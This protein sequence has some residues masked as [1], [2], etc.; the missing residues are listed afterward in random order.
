MFDTDI[1]DSPTNQKLSEFVD[2]SKTIHT[3]AQIVAEWNMNMFDNI[4]LVG[5]YKNRPGEDFT[6][7]S[8]FVE[9]TEATPNKQYLGFTDSDVITDGGYTDDGI[10]LTFLSKSQKNKILYSLEDCFQRFR[11]RSGINKLVMF[12]G[13]YISGMEFD[14]DTFIRPRYYL[15]D[16]DDKFKYWTSYRRESYNKGTDAVEE[17]SSVSIGFNTI[18]VTGAVAATV[19]GE[20]LVTYAI[21]NLALSNPIS[22]GQTISVSGVSPSQFNLQNVKVVSKTL[23]SVT[24]VSEQDFTAIFA[25]GGIMTSVNGNITYT[26]SD[27]GA[28][29]FAVGDVLSIRDATTASA[30]T[31]VES[32][33]DK[34]VVTASTANSFTIN[35]KSYADKIWA[36]T[37]ADPTYPAKPGRIASRYDFSQERGIAKVSSNASTRYID[38]AAPFVAYNN[39]VPANRI[40]T[41]MQ[42]NVS[43]Q[44]DKSKSYGNIPDPFYGSA[45]KTVPNNWKIQYLDSSDNWVNAITLSDPTKIP[46]DGYVEISYGML[47]TSNTLVEGVPLYDYSDTHLIFAEE[48][49]SAASL[50]VRSINNYAYLV[51]SGTSVGTY[52][53]WSDEI[54]DY[55]TFIPEYG[56]YLSSETPSAKTPYVKDLTSPASYVVSGNTY[57]RDIQYIKGIRI[58]VDTMNVSDTPFNLIELSPRLVADLTDKVTKVSMN[59]SSADLGSLGLPIG[60]LLASTGSITMFDYDMSFNSN[61]KNSILNT[62]VDGEYK[63]S[64]PSNNL[65]FKMYDVVYDDNGVSYHVPIKTMYVDGLPQT[66]HTNRTVDLKLRDLFFLFESSNAPQVLVPNASVSFAVASLLDS[67]GFSNYIFYREPDEVETVIPYFYVSPDQNVAQVLQD[68]AI[69]TQTA[70]FFDEYNNFVVMSRNYMLSKDRASDS[71]SIITIKGSKDSVRDGIVSN[72]Q[73]GSLSSIIDIASE[74]SEVF[75]DGKIQFN[76]RYIQRSYGTLQEASLLNTDR[77]WYYQPVLLWEVSPPEN[78]RPINDT[79]GNQ[80]AYSLA[81]IP[82]KADLSDRV[83]TVNP[84]GTIVDNTIDLGEAVYWLPRYNGFF[85]SAGEVIK[86]DAVRYNVPTMPVNDL[87]ADLLAGTKTVTLAYGSTSKM[88]VGQALTEI[89]NGTP[90]SFRIVGASLASNIATIVTSTPHNLLAGN[91]VSVDLSN[92]V[93][94]GQYRITAVTPTTISYAKTSASIAPADLTGRVVSI[95]DKYSVT[96]RSITNNVATLTFGSSHFLNVGDTVLVES[97]GIE[98]NGSYEITAKTSTT[99][100]YARENA[101]VAETTS[102]DGYVTLGARLKNDNAILAPGVKVSKIVNSTKFEV[103]KPHVSTGRA[104]MTAK[105][106]ENLFWIR[107]AEEYGN[108]FSKMPFGGKMYPNGEVR[109]FVEPFYNSDG[110]VK[111]GAVARHGRGQFSTQ[112]TSHSAGIR[113]EWTDKS[114]KDSDGKEIAGKGACRMK[115]EILFGNDKAPDTTQGTKAGVSSKRAYTSGVIRSIGSSKIITEDTIKDQKQPSTGTVQASALIMSGPV[116]GS[117]EK[118][119]RHIMYSYKKLS[120]SYQHYGTRMRIVGELTSSDGT[121][122]PTG[123]MTFADVKNDTGSDNTKSVAGSSGGIG[124]FVNPET[125]Q[126]YYL[127]AVAITDN[128]LLAYDSLYDENNEDANIYNVF[129]YK[130][131]TEKGK[132][133]DDQ[134]IPVPLWKGKTQITVDDG[135]FTGQ[136]KISG[137]PNS[138]VN[139]LAIEYKTNSKD[140]AD[141]DFYIYINDKLVATVTDPMPLPKTPNVALFIRGSSKCMFE[142]VYAIKSRFGDQGE[143]RGFENPPVSNEV[144]GFDNESLNGSLRKFAVSGLIK[145]TVLRGINGSSVPNYD[146]YY[147]EFGSIMRECASFNIKYDKAY[148]ALYAKMSP[149]FNNLQAYSVSG[150]TANAYGAEFMIFNTSDSTINLDSTSGNFLRIQGVTFTQQTQNELTVDE[151][152]KKQSDFNSLS[153]GSSGLSAVTEAKNTLSEIK[154][155][156]ITYG[157]KEFALAAPYIQSQDAANNMMEWIISKLMKPR[158]SIGLKIFSNPLIQI[159]D[160]IKI[161]Y[162]EKSDPNDS[163]YQDVLADADKVFL[164]YH[165]EY[166]RS[167]DGP[168]MTIYVSE[169]I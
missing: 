76:T 144:F 65:Q 71:E 139:D 20:M 17:I 164:V 113:A 66:S 59:K 167:V 116:F 94:D 37:F 165:I 48:Y 122:S 23:V 150:F 72:K 4:K 5:N 124:I 41:K 42:T 38:D 58:V 143:Y 81:A 16:K 53:V 97:L 95:Q 133:A 90:L 145:D 102:G 154:D 31:I 128:S 28:N 149:T 157:K 6:I 55:E 153:F 60:Q 9:E 137:E 163:D 61:N 39:P 118:P 89:S 148:P 7:A 123:A 93:F 87:E 44:T 14:T 156:R 98:F 51:K 121:Q 110:S 104:Y 78:V 24:V 166:S 159:G 75:N 126:G 56:W 120:D 50:P 92:N 138:S 158:K 40:I 45:N 67:I 169:V 26:Y 10:P 8:T 11:P 168:D 35:N 15:A 1:V 162:V 112:V 141:L 99:I 114:T 86:Y 54:E 22:V 3:Q 160:M 100:S 74:D 19:N 25:S 136:Y 57:Y 82:L 125:N 49:S 108:Y 109:I 13:K 85:Y 103:D 29:A 12:P 47:Y 105:E 32:I 18:A 84:S 107:D 77:T 83:P 80:S 132:S 62:F 161:D 46:D 96:K 135:G 147:E 117:T 127:E 52:H 119:L 111:K 142:N 73:D 36:N 140:A 88:A 129:F 151:Y 34:L 63:Y 134:A 152:M 30:N 69:S 131:Q 155:S 101:N 106:S 70:M 2:S 64:V 43:K 21:P 27:V 146:M 130:I 33:A 91:V 68:I 79:G 115:P